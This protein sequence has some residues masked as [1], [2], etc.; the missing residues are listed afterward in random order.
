MVGTKGRQELRRP[1]AL[2]LSV[3]RCQGLRNRT[4]TI[5]RS[6]VGRRSH[7]VVRRVVGWW[8][9]SAE[10]SWLW[11]P[12]FLASASSRTGRAHRDADE[13]KHGSGRVLPGSFPP[14]SGRAKSQHV[15]S[16]RDMCVFVCERVIGMMCEL[17]ERAVGCGANCEACGGVWCQR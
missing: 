13:S 17:G 4:E 16:R 6:R 14:L 11:P 15:S 1:V 5:R 2:R 12:H 9:S 7:T 10:Q 3:P 8:H